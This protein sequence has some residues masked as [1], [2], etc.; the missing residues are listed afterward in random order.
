MSK[1]H[2]LYEDERA[3]RMNMIEQVM[4]IVFTGDHWTS[5][6]NDN[7]LGV[8]VHFIDKEWKL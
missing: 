6:N 7:Y 4:Q 5:V 3:R 2:T 8:T 1:I